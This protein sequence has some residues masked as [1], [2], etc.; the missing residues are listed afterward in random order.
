ME[1]QPFSSHLPIKPVFIDTLALSKRLRANG[2]TEQQAEVQAQIWNEIIDHNLAT[3]QDLQECEA[4]LRRD[5]KETEAALR[6]DMKQIEANLDTKI[7]QIR[8]EM[9]TRFKELEYKMTLKLGSIVM[10]GLGA[11]TAIVK[12][13]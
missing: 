1:M 4:T 9:N 10:I 5:L 12:L 2:Y 3:K 6:R 13:L 8:A 11:M 7:E